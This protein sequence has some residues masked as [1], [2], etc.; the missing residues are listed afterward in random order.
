MSMHLPQH[1]GPL[2]AHGSVLSLLRPS[3]FK[4]FACTLS[5]PN[6]ELAW[7]DCRSI[8]FESGVC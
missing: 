6:L 3:D 2:S 7:E 1:S 5:S 8:S 4:I